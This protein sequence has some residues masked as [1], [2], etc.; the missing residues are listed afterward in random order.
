M[1]TEIELFAAV[2]YGLERILAAELRGFGA[3][4]VRPGRSGVAFRGTLEVAY[5]TCL[6]SRVAS[7]VLLP[8]A[9]FP[10]TDA[11]TLYAGIHELAWEDHLA[12]TGTLAVDANVAQSQLTHSQFVAQKTKDAVVDRLRERFGSRPSVDRQRPDLRINVY[13][14]RDRARVSLD[15]AG[16]SLHRRGYRAPGAPAPLKENLAAGILLLADWPSIAADGGTLLDPLCGS[17][18]LLIEGA[19]M[20]ADIAPGLLREWFGFL[21]W[22]NHQSAL[23]ASLLAEAHDR[24]DAGL[25]R[26]P[27]IVGFDRDPGAVRAALGS[28]R[29]AGLGDRIRVETGELANADPA[30]LPAGLVATNPP[31]GERLEAIEGL[32]TLYREL[33]T[34]LRGRFGGWRSAIFTGNPPLLRRTGLPERENLTLFNGPIECRLTLSEPIT[35]APLPKADDFANRLR[36][37]LRH[38][39]RWARREGVDCWRLYDADL[40]DYALAV[41][42]YMS[43]RLWV[44]VQEYEAPATVAPDRAAARLEAALTAIAKVLELP[45]ERVILKVRRRQRGRAQYERQGTGG[46]F[47]EVTEEGVRLLVNLT[48]YLDTGLFLDHRITRTLLRESAKGKRFLNLFAY[49]G[50]ATVHAAAGGASATTSVDLSN[51]YLE[52]ARRNLALNGFTGDRHRLIRADILEWL[53]QAWSGGERFELIF[54]DPPSFSNSKRM[55]ESFDIQRDHPDLLRRTLRLLTPDGTLIFSTNRRRFRLESAALQGYNVEE[56]TRATLPPDFARRPEAHRC[57]QITGEKV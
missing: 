7:R 42:L 39:G 31:Y 16:E 29:Q 17:G 40:P 26:L 51:T 45:R 50:S 9:R 23:W 18:T 54:L 24:R 4:G 2:P 36:K 21:G 53:D 57:W 55:E 35:E 14:H 44:H 30:D 43:D 52:W 12:P 37:N 13:I 19:L 1:T 33:G 25:T 46:R 48:D 8:L 20:A 6:W 49:T 22:P 38:L 32:E 41:D 15:L 11:E 3:E 27:A 28:T 34:V 56:I 5:R 10:A 47:M